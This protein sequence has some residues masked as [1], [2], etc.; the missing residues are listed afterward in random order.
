[1]N[2]CILSTSSLACTVVH[3]MHVLLYFNINYSCSVLILLPTE[4]VDEFEVS[5]CSTGFC[6]LEDDVDA[7]ETSTSSPVSLSCCEGDLI[8][9]LLSVDGDVVWGDAGV[10][11]VVIVVVVVVACVPVDGT[12]FVVIVVLA[13]DTVGSGCFVGDPSAVAVVV[14]VVLDEDGVNSC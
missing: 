4:P 1:M 12:W 9:W 13:E 8:G 3:S 7:G 2:I 5:M 10:V 6:V 11:V 14:D